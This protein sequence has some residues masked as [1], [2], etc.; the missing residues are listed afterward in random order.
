MSTLPCSRL[1]LLQN[2]LG[3]TDPYSFPHVLQL[4]F[5]VPRKILSIFSFN[6]YFVYMSKEYLSIFHM[7]QFSYNMT[8]CAFSLYL[9]YWGLVLF[10]DSRIFVFSSILKQFQNVWNIWIFYFIFSN[11][12][13]F[14][15]S[16]SR[17]T[18]EILCL[19]FLI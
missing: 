16:L 9:S 15:S 6:L 14:L 7:L 8:K 17:T 18:M 10:P 11:I 5:E 13:C 12:V 3:A 19:D 4:G 2:C 1:I